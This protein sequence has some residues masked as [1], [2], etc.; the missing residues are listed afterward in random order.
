MGGG[1]ESEHFISL[2]GTNFRP[3]S[4]AKMKLLI[5]NWPIYF[6]SLPL[7]FVRY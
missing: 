1:N 7:Q 2:F 6:V 3:S 4:K 5:V